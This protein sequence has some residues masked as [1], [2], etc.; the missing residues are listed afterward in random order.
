MSYQCQKCRSTQPHGTP[1][2]RVVVETREKVYPP[3]KQ[4]NGADDPGGKG[5]E[6]V[7]EMVVCPACI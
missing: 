3:R 5:H 4:G 6:T 7:R 1:S 2:N